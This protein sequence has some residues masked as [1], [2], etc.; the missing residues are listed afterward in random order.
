MRKSAKKAKSEQNEN[1]TIKIKI[2]TSIFLIQYLCL[3]GIFPFSKS[4]P[5]IESSW[6]TAKCRQRMSFDTW[7]DIVICARLCVSFSSKQKS[8]VFPKH[9]LKSKV[10]DQ[11]IQARKKLS[12]HVIVKNYLCNILCKFLIKIEST[13]RH[14][15]KEQTANF[16]ALW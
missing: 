1:S 13:W 8:T 5:E 12:C 15:I 14:K 7:H 4:Y 10:H 2:F 16:T 6:S 11:S 9:I 3:Y